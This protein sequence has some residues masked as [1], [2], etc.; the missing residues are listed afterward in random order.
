MKEF[1][2][3]YEEGAIAMKISVCSVLEMNGDETRSS[4]SAQR[5]GTSSRQCLFFQ[6]PG[7]RWAFSKK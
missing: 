1:H 2:F 7:T 4:H 6:K 3:H 5:S